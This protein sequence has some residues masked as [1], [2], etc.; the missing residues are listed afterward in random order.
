[1][2][3]THTWLYPY[4]AEALEKALDRDLD[5]I[6]PSTLGEMLTWGLGYVN[7]SKPTIVA[8]LF[9]HRLDMLGGYSVEVETVLDGA[10]EEAFRQGYRGLAEDLEERGDAMP[11]D[12]VPYDDIPDEE[13]D[14][15]MA[16]ALGFIDYEVL[17]REYPDR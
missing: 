14:A 7:Y 17:A 10:S 9:S 1:M 8:D 4:N 16:Y 13:F 3:T 5:S 6:S 12:W 2:R 11:E 15:M